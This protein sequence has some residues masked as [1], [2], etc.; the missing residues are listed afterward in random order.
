LA[1][2]RRTWLRGDLIAGVTVAAYL[3]PQ[4]MANG[5]LAGLPPVAGYGPSPAVGHLR[6]LGTSRKLSVGPESTTALM[7]AT[8]IAPLAGGDTALYAALAAGLAV[9]AGLLCLVAW[10]ARLG[11][12]A[13]LLSK[14]ILVGYLAEVALIMIAGQLEKI[15]GVPVDGR[16]FFAELASFAQGLPQIDAATL[17]CA[18]AVLGFLLVAQWRFPHAPG[19]LLA[20]LFATVPSWCSGWSAT[21]YRWSV[22]SR[23]PASPG[24]PCQT[25]AT[26]RTS[27]CRR[28][29]SFSWATPTRC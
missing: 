22:P 26:S 9:V 14:P 2:Y 5:S 8:V 28:W 27:S 29:A 13:S 17:A 24:L 1:G 11:F 12:I 21:A 23:P 25:S 19:P 20:V 15:T 16:G 18:A 3:V 10:A 4:V 7:T 6:V